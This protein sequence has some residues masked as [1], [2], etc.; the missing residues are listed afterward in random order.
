MFNLRETHP[1]RTEE[2]SFLKTEL[3]HCDS[4]EERAPV[5]DPERRQS[6][7]PSVTDTGVNE[8]FLSSNVREYSSL[9][10]QLENF[11]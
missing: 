4:Q 8:Q 2:A 6:L 3:V 11:Q 7:Y 9:C 5:S 10:H 1:F